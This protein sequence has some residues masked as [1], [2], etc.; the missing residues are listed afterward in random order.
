MIIVD[1]VGILLILYASAH[2]AYVGGSFRQ[3]IHNVLEAA[4]YGIPVCSDRGTG[5]PTNLS[6]WSKGAEH[7][8]STTAEEL[9]R[10]LENLLTDEMART[11][12]GNRAR[13]LF[14][15]M[16]APRIGS[17]NTWNA[18]CNRDLT[19]RRT[20]TMKIAYLDTIAGIAGDMTLA[21]FV[22]AGVPLDEL[23][24]ELRKLGLDGFELTARHVQRNSIDAVHLD[25]VVTHQPHYHRHLKDIRRDHRQQHAHAGRQG[26]GT[27]D[28]L[29]HRRSGGQ[30]P[31]HAVGEGTLS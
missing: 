17:S 2:I 10:T 18:T 30:G 13:D 9:H 1:S 21:A 4:V 16:S 28:F 11:T 7:S 6:C 3:G 31:Q 8:S 19:T 23:A 29:R 14:S 12:T 20:H 25:V 27:G 24:G 15:R 5:I 22:A 26:K